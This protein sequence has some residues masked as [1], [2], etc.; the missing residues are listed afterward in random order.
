MI[1]TEPVMWTAPYPGNRETS[2]LE[3]I[4]LSNSIPFYIKAPQFLAVS[5]EGSVSNCVTAF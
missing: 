1:V 4:S 3:G 5:R 2:D